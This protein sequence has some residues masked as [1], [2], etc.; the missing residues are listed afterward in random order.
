MA[1]LP[2]SVQG[3]VCRAG[4][5]SRERGGIAQIVAAVQQPHHPIRIDL[6][7]C[8]LLPQPCAAGRAV[9][10]GLG[11]PQL[12]DEQPHQ[13]TLLCRQSRRLALP[14]PHSFVQGHA[15]LP[16]GSLS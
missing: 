9:G 12:A 8:H 1:S 4:I 3:P 5:E 11:I 2:P 10:S 16:S 6:Q 7:G 15:L 14:V 13:L